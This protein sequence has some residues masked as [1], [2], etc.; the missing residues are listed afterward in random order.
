[1]ARRQGFFDDLMSIGLRLPW[2]VGVAVAV[3]IFVVLHVVA[4]Y[5]QTPV[6]A[7]SLGDIGVVVQHQFIHLFA[8]FFQYI[9]PAGLLIGTT[10][11]YF[12]QRRSDAQFV[13]ARANPK[14]AITSMSWRDFEKLV[15][16]V[17][18]RQGFTVSGFGGQGPDGG[19]D[20]GLTKNGQRF[21]VQCKHWR[22]RQVGV[23]VVRELNGVVSA[24][25][26]HGGFVVT[27]GEFSREAREFA[28]ACDIKLIDGP[29]LGELIGDMPSKNSAG[30][31]G[32]AV[33][34]ASAPACPRCGLSM[35]ER[36]AKQGKFVGKPFWG[37]QQ[38]P[39]C[40]GI[41]RIS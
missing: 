34:A 2:K 15:G 6:S 8:E 36:K 3:V 24:Q 41:V 5:T 28:N 31:A 40:S 25:G 17:F 27:G 33:V 1:M 12:K 21:L 20:L 32:V 38:Y 18:R 9:I 19:V 4:V 26:A 7:N 39:K 11:G 22:K 14:P 13:S 23:T 16:E 30:E 10:V 29:A 37:C 35:V